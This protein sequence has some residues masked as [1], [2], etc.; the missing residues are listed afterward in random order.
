[1]VR[2]APKGFKNK[3]KGGK[4]KSLSKKAISD[5]SKAT[6]FAESIGSD[7]KFSDLAKQYKQYD[8][9][10]PDRPPAF[11]ASY[12][13]EVNKVGTPLASTYYKDPV[14]GEERF[15]TASPPT[16]KQLMGDIGRGLFSGY[17]TLSYDPNAGGI[18]TTT[19]GQIVRRQG[20]FPL[21]ANKAMSG[22][23]GLMGLAKGLYDRFKS[24]TQQ[25]IE[26]VGGLYD[27]LRK[28]LGG[29]E[30]P[31]VN[32]GGS[33]DITVTEQPMFPYNFETTLK[34]K[35]DPLLPS[36][37]S[38]EQ[39]ME[40][41]PELYSSL[42]QPRNYEPIR[43][44]DMSMTGVTAQ[45]GDRPVLPENVIP[46]MRVGEPMNI[47]QYK[48]PVLPPEVT[49][50]RMYQ[51]QTLYAQN[52]GLPSLKQSYDFL[53]N[54]QVETSLGNLR[55]DNV[56]SGNPQLGYG[57]TVMING[58]PVDLSATIGQGGVSGGL[59]FAFKKGGSVDKYAGLG[60]KLK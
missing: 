35:P 8:V 20:L 22:E 2:K 13:D 3:A 52:F 57:N 11:R 33:S 46:M 30:Q 12:G 19:G 60:Y 55:F 31:V 9:K 53:R 38:Q 56:L 10:Y 29:G 49:D 47:D 23:F 58:V 32:Y 27:N 6:R 24:G 15:F 51:G 48:T 42:Y 45:E 25:G 37:M 1:M 4:G 14:T 18:P 43:V 21:L 7:K 28:T 54:P 26:T 50:P 36:E 39:F 40:S 16:F 17:N 34:P 41:F 5:I 44:S 59:S